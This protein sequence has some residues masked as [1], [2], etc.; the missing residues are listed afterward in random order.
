[1]T[2][3]DPRNYQVHCEDCGAK[4]WISD[5]HQ[6]CPCV[7]CGEC[8]NVFTPDNDTP[9]NYRDESLCPS[10]EGILETDEYKLEASEVEC[11]ECAELLTS[12]DVSDPQG[13]QISEEQ[14]N[15]LKSNN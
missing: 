15:S 4:F 5:G 3:M 9:Y 14:S 7:D 10:C 6:D 1:M 2:W 8:R 13:Y 12:E 11:P